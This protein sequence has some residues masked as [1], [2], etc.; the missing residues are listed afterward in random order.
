M[1]HK[2]KRISQINLLSEKKVLQFE[3]EMAVIDVELDFLWADKSAIEWPDA[4]EV[5]FPID[6]FKD[7][8]ETT[9]FETWRKFVE[10]MA[11]ALFQKEE[12]DSV[13]T[14]ACLGDLRNYA[15]KMQ[16]GIRIIPGNPGD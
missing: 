8:A 11:D 13:V 9:Q 2:A 10:R 3:R 5:R 1:F 14:A 7:R 12:Q 16:Q 15:R 6:A 4:F